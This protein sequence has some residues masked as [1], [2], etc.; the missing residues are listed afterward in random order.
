MSRKVALLLFASLFFVAA[1]GNVATPTNTVAVLPRD[2]K[3]Q[4]NQQMPFSLDG[5]ISPNAVVSWEANAGSISFAPPGLN[6]LFTAPAQPTV[7]TISVTISSGT[8]SVQIP[9]TV[10]CYIT[11]NNGNLP[12]A[13]EVTN[14][15][16]SVSQVI[17]DVPATQPTV[18]ISEVMA[19]PCGGI[20]FKKWNEYVEI[21]NFGDLPVDVNGWWL[22]DTGGNGSPDQIVSWA[23]RNPTKPLAGSLI[24]SSTIIPAK[25]YALIL[26]PSYA[27]GEFPYAQPYA[28]PAN[29]VILT[30]AESHS[31]GDD[32]SSIVGDGE[33]RDVLVLYKGGPSVIQETI[34]TYGTPKPAQ[35]V[36]D[37][38][39][40]Y[41]DNL[42]RDLHECSSIERIVPTVADSE[43]NWREVPYGSPGEA[44]Y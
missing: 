5:V 13:V 43:D 38:K 44:P 33:G 20:E 14:N 17:S 7:V 24:L 11:D 37:V 1:C 40:N 3:M 27:D 23:Q 28:I 21:Y 15:G 32:A 34:S 18:I 26:S 4:V 25:G 6:A 31:L 12:T 2:C 30:A 35:Y 39:D 9:I 41:L 10:Q 16:V 22:A 36:S 29:T 42:P 8:P 19:N